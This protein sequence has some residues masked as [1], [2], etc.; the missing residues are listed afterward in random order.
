MMYKCSE[1][2]DITLGN[3]EQ[4]GKVLFELFSDNFLKGNADKCHLVLSTD[5]TFYIKI[6]NKAIEIVTIKNC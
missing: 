5:E 4:A 2:V 3:L 6:G 1:N